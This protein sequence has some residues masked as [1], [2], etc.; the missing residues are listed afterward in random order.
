MG[1]CRYQAELELATKVALEAGA[2]IREEFHREGGPRSSARSHAEVDEEVELL[3]RAQLRAAWPLD[4][5]VGEETGR[6]GPRDAARTWYVDPHDGTAAFVQGHR[7][8]A[9][10]LGL[11][12]DGVPV[13][14]VVYAPT[15]PD[16]AGTLVTW[17]EGG[18]LRLNGEPVERGPLPAELDEQ[19]VVAFNA[20][21]WAG[22]PLSRALG[23]ASPGRVLARASVAYRLALVA[24]GEA[25]AAVSL[26]CPAD[27]DVA[28]GHALLRAVGGVLLDGR[29]APV[30]Y[31]GA[32]G[33][34]GN[35]FGGHPTVAALLAKR[36]SG[37]PP[38]RLPEDALSEAYPH[39]RPSHRLKVRDAGRLARA[40]GA[41]L[42]QVVGDALGAQVEFASRTEVFRR[43]PG[44]VREMGPGGPFQ[45]LP[46]QPTDDTEMALVLAR[47]ILARGGFDDE[48]VRQGYLAW[49]ASE[50]FD[51]GSTTRLGLEGGDTSGSQANG[52]VMRI[53]PLAVH[54]WRNDPQAVMSVAVQDAVLT[55]E[56]FV[57]AEA[58]V[59]F[60]SAVALAVREGLPPRA[61]YDRVAAWVRSEPLFETPVKELFSG[62]DVAPVKD[63]HTHAGWVLVALRNAFHQLLHAPSFEEGLVRTVSQGGDSDTNGAI[64]GAL[65]GAV[66]GR[67]AVPLRWRRTVL[68]CRA[69][70]GR[71][72]RP[73]PFWADDLLELAEQ[74]VATGPLHEWKRDDEPGPEDVVPLERVRARREAEAAAREA[75]RQ[76]AAGA[77]EALTRLRQLAEQVAVFTGLPVMNDSR[78]DALGVSA[79]V[80]GLAQASDVDAAAVGS[81]LVLLSRVAAGTV[82]RDEGG[83]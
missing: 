78:V 50:P 18:S 80:R 1:E 83:T 39:A 12:V 26:S 55:H 34:P 52:S 73:A 25:D 59:V 67:E 43:F 35:V 79:P 15:A 72:V 53:S 70:T 10:S 13:L 38:V 8:S 9:V 44:G 71:Q 61:L 60:A 3:I 19:T 32:P 36:A 2:R 41:L 81:A 56:S 66:Y 51:V 45:T 20:E 65:L 16:D 62:D 30:R 58:T 48:P 42:G 40:Q 64:A 74:L 69:V 14:G 54:L 47:T 49:L 6:D 27:Y 22:E 75:L 37:C 7:G 5:Y 77:V 28:G 76:E 82:E 21:A 17:A 46:G 63:F 33:A 57:C 4:G 68:S 23:M 24:V 29:G 11:V 31:G